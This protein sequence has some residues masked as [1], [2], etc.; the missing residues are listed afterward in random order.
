[1][2]DDEAD[3]PENSVIVGQYIELLPGV[4]WVSSKQEDNGF[5]WVKFHLDI[6]HPTAWHIIQSLGYVFNS[7][8][9]NDPLPVVFFPNSSP[10]DMN[11]GPND[12]LYWVLEPRNN[13]VKSE[14]IL[15]AL[16]TNLLFDVEKTDEWLAW[17]AKD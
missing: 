3:K 5:W 7:L 16:R 4:E 6:T 14:E 8:S 13:N 10:P 12:C 9:L 11:G 15:K 2:S 1:M 17:P